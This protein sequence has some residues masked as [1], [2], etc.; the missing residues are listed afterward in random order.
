MWLVDISGLRPE[1]AVYALTP[2]RILAVV[3]A[4][5]VM[6][7]L[8]RAL[9]MHAPMTRQ[10]TCG[11]VVEVAGILGGLLLT[12]T[13]LNLIGATAAAL[14]FLAGRLAGNVYL[15]SPCMRWLRQQRDRMG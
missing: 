12:I 3:P 15:L 5:S 8:Q 1:L 4:L 14:S 13:G 9:L 2:L 7:A 6:Q 10:V 11:T